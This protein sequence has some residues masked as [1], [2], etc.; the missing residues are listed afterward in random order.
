[1]R[2]HHATDQ[3][4]SFPPVVVVGACGVKMK[5]PGF[6]SASMLQQ[7]LARGGEYSTDLLFLVGCGS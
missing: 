3:A 4:V 5:R 7:G 1:M 2:P 6:C